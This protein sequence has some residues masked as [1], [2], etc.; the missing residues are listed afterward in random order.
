MSGLGYIC[1]RC[2]STRISCFYTAPP[3]FRCQECGADLED[4][5]AEP[6]IPRLTREEAESK[7]PQLYG[8]PMCECCDPVT[9]PK[10]SCTHA[11]HGPGKCRWC[12]KQNEPHVYKFRVVVLS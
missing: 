6:A 12:N 5:N 9:N 1:P 2:G 4:E 7:R 11:P 10:I 3:S 8:L